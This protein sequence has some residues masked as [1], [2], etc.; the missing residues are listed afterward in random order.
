MENNKLVSFNIKKSNRLTLPRYLE[1]LVS[2]GK[3]YFT[4]QEL[5]TALGMNKN[6]VSASLSRLGKRQRVKMIRKGFGVILGFGGAE[7]DPSYFIDAM[8]EHLDIRYYVGLLTAAKYWGAGHQASMRYQIVVSRPVYKIAFGKIKIEFVVKLGTFPD[9]G[10]KK[11][12]GI[13]GYFKISS[14]ELTAIDVV[15]FVRKSGHLNN[16]AT[17]LEDLSDQLD[18]KALSLVCSDALTPTVTLQRLGYLF[19]RILEREDDAKIVE[20]GLKGRRSVTTYLSQAK[21][22]S[23]PK[24]SDFK[25]DERWKLYINTK[26]EP[27]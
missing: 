21:I 22:K 9:K 1:K 10:I 6:T 13:G 4:T 7:P 23:H 15:H 25:Y 3:H 20:Q 5:Q 26:V 2:E 19:E 12:G 27:D 11:I 18:G 17:V 16:V 8:M 14:P 24:M